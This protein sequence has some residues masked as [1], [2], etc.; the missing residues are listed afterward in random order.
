M[1]TRIISWAY[2]DARIRHPFVNHFRTIKKING[3]NNTKTN[4]KAVAGGVA[5][6]EWILKIP[7]PPLLPEESESGSSITA[8]Y[9]FILPPDTTRPNKELFL[10]EV[11]RI[12]DRI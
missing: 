8:R 3:D 10:S 7:H 5:S 1:I 11:D 6:L 2:R 4:P 9:R 12:W